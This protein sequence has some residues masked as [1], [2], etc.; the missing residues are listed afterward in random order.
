MKK[1]TRPI[2]NH[3]KAK[4]EH[5]I[6][7]KKSVAGDLLSKYAVHFRAAGPARRGRAAR[8]IWEKS[9]ARACSAPRPRGAGAPRIV[10]MVEIVSWTWITVTK[11]SHRLSVSWSQCVKK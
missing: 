10:A 6:M 9:R 1:E 2:N 8:D 5:E 11:I 3:A 4:F 7:T